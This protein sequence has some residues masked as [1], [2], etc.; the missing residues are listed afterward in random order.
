MATD[1]T[2]SPAP[3]STSSE[4]AAPSESTSEPGYHLE[5]LLV[6]FAAL[7]LEISYTR[8]VSFKLFYYYTYL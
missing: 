2:S 8:V 3:S 1:T 5:I 4:P 6:S 7:L